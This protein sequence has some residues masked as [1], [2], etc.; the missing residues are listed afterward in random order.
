M[1]SPRKLARSLSAEPADIAVEEL[2]RPVSTQRKAA[3]PG[4]GTLPGARVSERTR[5]AILS[6]QPIDAAT[7]GEYELS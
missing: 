1:K 2:A 5:E 6:L 3:K 4:V 7:D